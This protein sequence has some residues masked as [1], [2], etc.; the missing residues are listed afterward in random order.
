MVRLAVLVVVCLLLPGCSEQG[1]RPKVR[2]ATDFSPPFNFFDEQRRPT[3]FAVDVMNRAAQRAG[4]ELEWVISEVGPEATFASGR[5][6]LWPVVTVFEARRKEIHLTEPWWRLAT[7]MYFR[8]S[9]NIKS[10]NDLAGKR[11]LLTSPSKRYQPNARFH[12]TTK[13]GLVRNSAEGM[14]RLCTGEADAV[15]IDLRVADGALLNRPRACD[16]IRFG[17]LPMEEGVR[18]F[19]IGAKFGFEKEANRL[20][21][22]IDEIASEGE[23]VALASRWKFLDQTDAS[24]LEWLDQV[25]R[26]GEWWRSS[27]AGLGVLLIV[28]LVSLLL[29]QRSKHRAE[30]SAQARG[31]FLANM[32]HEIRTPMNG[33]LGMTELALATH[34][35][36]EQ[37]EYLQTA[38]DSGRHLLRILDDILDLSRVESGKLAIERIPFALHDVVQRSILALTFQAQEKGLRIRDEIN[39]SVPAWVEG[40]PSRLQQILVNLLGNATKFSERGEIVLRVWSSGDRIAFSVTDQ[41]IGIPVEQQARIFDAFTQADASTT[42]RYGG[43]G[44]G[45]AISSRL[46]QMMGGEL[47]LDSKPGLGSTFRFEIPLRSVESPPQPAAAPVTEP[48][49]PLSLLVAED[50]LVNRT[51][52]ERMMVKAGHRVRAVEDGSQAVAAMAEQQFDAVLMDVHMPVMDGLEA[53][54]LIREQERTTGRHVPIIALTALAI[55]GD[56]ER[57]LAAGMDSYLAKPYRREDLL[58]ALSRIDAPLPS[59]N[60]RG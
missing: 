7:V 3:G 60:E 35:D 28:S 43:T 53:T 4:I 23:M 22:A 55:R 29:V 46:V 11:L 41:G 26:N 44:L 2:I 20:R 37:R 21:A 40:D 17:A 38:H 45:L 56:A 10:L 14:E 5:A 30:L 6:E 33:V 24:L 49:R 50:N 47:R 58:A 16:G 31:Q 18:E 34:L 27:F 15:W 59:G 48:G 8:E 51:L 52:L 32:S 12:P 13:V 57:C 1:V 54:R 42:R 39:P 25:K 19:S 9:S 36:D